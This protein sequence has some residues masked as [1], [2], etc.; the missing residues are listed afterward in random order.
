LLTAANLN[1][2]PAVLHSEADG[3]GLVVKRDG[4]YVIDD[5]AR[6]AAEVLRYHTAQQD[7]FVAVTGRMM[8]ERCQE[9]P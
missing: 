2:V 4:H 9:P 6:T 8:T 7:Y 1:N 5:Q 3:L